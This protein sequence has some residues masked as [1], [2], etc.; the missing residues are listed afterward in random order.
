[1]SDLTRRDFLRAASALAGALAARHSLGATVPA[2]P[3]PVIWLQAQSCSGCS[4]SLLNSINEMSVTDL[5]T[6]TVSLKYHSTLMPAFGA[7]AVNVAT[8]VRA[9]KGYILV[10]EGAIPLGSLGKFCTLWPGQISSTGV[11]AFAQNAAFIIAAGTCASHG[12]VAAARPN[13]TTARSLGAVVGVT[14]VIN[15]PG[16]PMHP[17]WL[18]ATVAYLLANGAAPPLDS[19]RRPK[20][21]YG[22]KVHDLCPY[23]ENERYCLKEYGC[24]G[25][26]TYAD[27]PS[28][29]W[30]SP[31]AKTP[32]VAWCVTSGG[33]C[34]GCTEP[35]FP[36]AMSPFYSSEDLSELS[37]TRTAAAPSASAPRTEPPEDK[38]KAYQ[39]KLD[40]RREEYLRKK[41]GGSK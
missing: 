25:P 33:P 16:C 15:L 11:Q 29:R 40:Q 31:A 20:M 9:I 24:K 14:R 7:D 10:V 21:F 19:F 32:G 3:P 1:M 5:L 30:N 28:R 2:E 41:K 38:R 26:K 22:K 6:K 35:G 17:D 36:D 13:P 34:H 27:C 37:P 23:R 12:G 39:Q 4:V 18:V 8:T